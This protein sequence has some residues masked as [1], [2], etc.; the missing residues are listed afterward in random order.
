MDF[1]RLNRALS[2]PCFVRLPV[3]RPH[4]HMK[5]LQILRF[6]TGFCHGGCWGLNTTKALLQHLQARDLWG[7]ILPGQYVT[8]HFY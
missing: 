4:W 3:K 7:C 2:K 6:L 1:I 5:M 8:L